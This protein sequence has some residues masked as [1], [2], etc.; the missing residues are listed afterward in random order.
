MEYIKK[1]AGMGLAAVFAITL[2][3]PVFAQD[4]KYEQLSSDQI[5]GD[6]LV[7]PGKVELELNPGESE[8]V[9][10]TLSN[11]MGSEKTFTV[12]VEDF[13]G[14][15]STEQ[16]V[17]LLGDQRGPYSLQDYL[18]VPSQEMTVGHTERIVIPIT[19][20]VP[21]DAEP[22]GRYGSVLFQTK[23]ESIE[24]GAKP[25]A[26]II[27]RIGVLFFVTVPGDLKY[28]GNVEKFDTAFG[29]RVYDSG[30]IGFEILYR[31]TGNVHVNPYGRISVRNMFGSEVGAVELDPWF[32]MPEFL[33]LREVT[34]DRGWLFGKYK[35]V[36]SINKGYDNLVET[37][38]VVFYV[39]PWKPISVAV[40]IVAIFIFL[41][42]KIFSTFEIKRKPN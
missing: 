11:R 6:F 26:S 30:P 39:L 1:L 20:S 8:T 40:I 2:T 12:V 37:R 3:I 32:A 13:V 19:V 22:G 33:R 31:N 41:L 25:S 10:V 42:T 9:N 27:S 21:T 24:N 36:L 5:V 15:E 34:W 4:I 28:E 17:V 38:E 29:K 7:G 16:P 14:S 18:V 23:S 35:A